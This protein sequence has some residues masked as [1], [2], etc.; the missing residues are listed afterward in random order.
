MEMKIGNNQDARDALLK[1]CEEQNMSLTG[2]NVASGVGRSSLT[3]FV[4]QSRVV[5]PGVYAKENHLY[6]SSFVKAL[7]A[8]GYEVVVRPKVPGSRRERKLRAL[9]Q[10]GNGDGGAAA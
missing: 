4:F 7:D 6:I 9:R 5:S 2:L 10:G 1:A 3:R 8:A